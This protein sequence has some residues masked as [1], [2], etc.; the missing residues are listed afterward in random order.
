MHTYIHMYTCIHEHP[1]ANQM[2]NNNNTLIDSV[3]MSVS[4]AVSV[5]L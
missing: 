4:V 3:Y 5:W 2:S 1:I